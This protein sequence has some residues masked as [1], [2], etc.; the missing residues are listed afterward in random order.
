MPGNASQ[1]DVPTTSRRRRPSSR[2]AAALTYRNRQ[3]SSSKQKAAGMV[4]RKRTGSGPSSPRPRARQRGRVRPCA[5]TVVHGVSP[6]AT[7]RRRP[8]AGAPRASRCRRPGHGFCCARAPLRRRSVPARGGMCRGAHPCGDDR[9]GAGMGQSGGMTPDGAVPPRGAARRPPSDLLVQ[10]VEGME[11][12]L[13]VL[14]DD[15]RFRYINP[16]GAPVLDRTVERLVGR[17]SGRSSPRRSAARSSELY[18]RVAD[19]GGAGQL[20]GVVRAAADLVPGRCLPHRRRPR[21]HLRRRHRAPPDGGRAGRGRRRPREAAA[22]AAA[23]APPRPR[24]PA[25]T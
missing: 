13:F 23:R 19:T 2:S 18:R 17:V 5:L 25:G 12:P 3:C 1:S 14:D 21:R 24:W 11:R 6:R 10:A 7:A 22:E 4:S 8:L 15:W 9:A 20:R 16:A